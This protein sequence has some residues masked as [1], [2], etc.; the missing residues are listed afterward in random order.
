MSEQKM[1]LN[2]VLMYG[3]YYRQHY[4]FANHGAYVVADYNAGTI[5]ISSSAIQ[6]DINKTMNEFEIF[7]GSMIDFIVK[8]IACLGGNLG[9]Y[10][11]IPIDQWNIVRSAAA[12]QGE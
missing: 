2:D 4:Q 9:A 11:P 12:A 1:K 3:G 10:Q 8:H 6:N 5:K 7:D